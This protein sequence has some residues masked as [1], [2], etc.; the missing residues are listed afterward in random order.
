MQITVNGKIHRFEGEVSIEQIINNL[1]L[2]REHFAVAHNQ[3]VVPKSQLAGI[4]VKDGDKLEII[5]ATAGG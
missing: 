1:D 3:I 2:P 4:F 5:H